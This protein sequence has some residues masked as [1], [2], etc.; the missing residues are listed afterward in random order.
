MR[1]ETDSRLLF[2]GDSITDCNRSRPIGKGGL[3]SGLGDGYVNLVYGALTAMYPE[4]HIHVMNTG[5]SG[6]TV[7]DLAARW[8]SDALALLPDW[9]SV[10]IGI[11][12][13]WRQFDGLWKPEQFISH[14]EFTNTL[15]RLVA[16]IRPHLKGLVLMSPYYLQTDE[17]DAMRQR[18]D[19]YR[20][21]VSTLAEQHDAIYVDT[22]KALDGVL[23]YVDAGQLSHDRVHMGIV[24][25]TV[26][27][28]AFLKAIGC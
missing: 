4:N 3:T 22:Q 20:T 25:H 13:V 26:L 11:N 8:E 7:R 18:M 10:M 6:N 16:Q 28:Q 9:T 19:I 14:N 23:R 12:D 15:G 24:G 5:I 17:Q 2:I 1:L 21:A 27:A